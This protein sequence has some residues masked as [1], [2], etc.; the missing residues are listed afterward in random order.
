LK[1]YEIEY[2]NIDNTEI[3]VKVQSRNAEC[4]KKAYEAAIG[5]KVKNES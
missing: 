5:D 3:L 2:D 1:A 4:P